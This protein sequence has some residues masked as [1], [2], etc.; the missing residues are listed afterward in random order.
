MLTQ[1]HAQ[2]KDEKRDAHA[3]AHD[4]P[5]WAKT[6]TGKV[7]GVQGTADVVKDQELVLYEFMNMLVR[8]AFWRAN[9]NFGLH[10]NKDELVPIA[11]ALASMLND[12]IL[13][14]AKRENSTHFKEKE[15]HDMKLLAVIDQYK[16]R[17]R[18]WYD[19]KVAD[20]SDNRMGIVSD[21]LGFEE[22]LRVCDRQDIV[23]EWEV[24]Q[25]SEIT[26]DES[27][28]GN[29]KCR[30]S[31]PQVKNLFVDS[32]EK[33]RDLGAGE[34]DVKEKQSSLDFNEFCEMIARLGCSKPLRR[35]LDQ[36]DQLATAGGHG[37]S[38]EP[39]N[40]LRPSP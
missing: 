7:K 10:G 38:K 11:F 33:L 3:Q 24:E 28:K 1:V 37:S 2:R 40:C 4:K 16:P 34:A 22:W 27:T 15:M 23:G 19:K 5:E 26:G 29:I 12:V 13:P 17:L 30:L 18:E 6:K 8:I 39:S 14:R 31:I 9:P 20:D 21:K 32:Q 36:R 35:L 25:M